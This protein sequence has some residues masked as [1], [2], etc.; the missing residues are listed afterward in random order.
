L[1]VGAGTWQTIW[2]ERA[3]PS[4]GFGKPQNDGQEPLHW[5]IDKSNA[6]P[7]ELLRRFRSE[8]II[9][10]QAEAEDYT[11]AAESQLGARWL[12]EVFA[13]LL[14]LSRKMARN[15]APAPDS[16]GCDEVEFD[17]EPPDEIPF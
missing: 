6:I 10:P 3:K 5:A 11:E 1:I 8:L 17:S 12:E 14:C 7:P 15:L 16:V 9:L 4:L 13:R 2:S